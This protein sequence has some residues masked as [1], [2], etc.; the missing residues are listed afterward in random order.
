[1]VNMVK[2]ELCTSYFSSLKW[3][4]VKLKPGSDS[5]LRERTTRSSCLGLDGHS[6]FQ[7]PLD[8]FP[9]AFIPSE[10]EIPV[11][12]GLCKTET[13]FTAHQTQH[14]KG[15]C[16][17][18]SYIPNLYLYQETSSAN[19]CPFCSLESGTVRLSYFM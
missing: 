2:L 8:S 3:Q 7:L 11:S 12:S 1:M 9:G 14:D 15:V 18:I 10:S 16:E 19:L 13:S 5:V 17:V 4:E 6:V